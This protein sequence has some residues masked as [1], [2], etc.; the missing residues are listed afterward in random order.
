MSHNNESSSDH[1][2]DNS[3]T[4]SSLTHYQVLGVSSTAT[5]AE[6]KAAFSALARQSHPDKVLSSN[7]PTEMMDFKRIQAAWECLRDESS[8]SQ[9]DEELLQKSLNDKRFTKSAVVL[10]FEDLEEAYD[11]ETQQ[12]L[13][14]YDCRCGEEV[15][16][17]NNNINMAVDCPGCCFVYRVCKDDTS[18]PTTPT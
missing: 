9:Y 14:V 4:T 16:I 7:Q 2:F 17:A 18:N 1:D 11:E 12:T 3:T 6:L 5:Y 13:W 15:L 8:R 10:T